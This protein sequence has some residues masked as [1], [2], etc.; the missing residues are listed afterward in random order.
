MILGNK[1]IFVHQ[2]TKKIQIFFFCL[3][4]LLLLYRSMPSLSASFQAINERKEPAKYSRAWWEKPALL[5]RAKAGA[6]PKEPRRPV[7]RPQVQEY[8]V[9]PASP[10][11]A[12]CGT[13][14]R[15]NYSDLE[16][17]CAQFFACVS[18][19]CNCARARACIAVVVV[20]Q[21]LCPEGLLS[22]KA[23]QQLRLIIHQGGR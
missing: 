10:S 1:H 9:G 6:R 15:R 2:K 4:A 5:K 11:P 14:L 8:A 18:S 7:Q 23:V 21:N 16:W 3:R 20:Q 13:G 12:S 19:V 22:V 17:V